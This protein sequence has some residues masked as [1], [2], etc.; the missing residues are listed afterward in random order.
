M[1]M[2]LIARRKYF[3]TFSV[4]VFL[5]S[6]VSLAV[7]GLKPGLDFTGGSLLEVS[8]SQDRPTQEA[9]SAALAP[10]NLGEIKIQSAG[11]HDLLLRSR[12]IDEDTHQRVLTALRAGVP[13]AT[14]TELRFES[15][16]P[17]VG[18]E[19]AQKA[20]I[21]IVVAVLAIVAYIAFAFRKVSQPVA[22]WKYGLAAIVAL[23]HDIL[24]VT[25]LFAVLGHFAG[26]EVD[27]LFITALL[28]ILGFSVH[29]TI[30]VFDRTRENLAHRAGRSFDDVVNESVNQTM[31]RSINTS[32]TTVIVLSAL[33]LFGGGSIHNFV[34]A[35]LVGIIIGTYSSI[36][37]ASPLIV[38]WHR[39]DR[40]RAA[41]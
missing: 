13:A 29:D 17:A 35:L 21:A 15:V 23:I 4:I 19:M 20:W 41:R 2:P 32:L 10:L 18:A 5:A 9:V 22:S 12:D 3:Y 34:L 6:I 31:A 7:W 37:V 40:W 24:I 36:F 38:D 25:G 30:V 33:L 27:A 16:G 26:V 8:Y 11:E 14:V 39:F 28:T 1:K